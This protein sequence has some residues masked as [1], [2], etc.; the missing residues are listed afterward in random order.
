MLNSIRVRA[1]EAQNANAEQAL[2]NWISK[3]GRSQ[4]RESGFVQEAPVRGAEERDEEQAIIDEFLDMWV[5][6]KAEAIQAINKIETLIESPQKER[7]APVADNFGLEMTSSQRFGQRN[8]LEL[9]QLQH[10]EGPDE[11][12]EP[13]DLSY[14]NALGREERK[15]EVLQQLD[16]HLMRQS[17]L[18]RSKAKALD[19]FAD[20]RGIDL[21]NAEKNDILKTMDLNYDEAAAATNVKRLIDA[22]VQQQIEQNLLRRD[23]W[24]LKD[25]ELR[26]HIEEWLRTYRSLCRQKDMP[27][28]EPHLRDIIDD[29]LR[30]V[31]DKLSPTKVSEKLARERSDNPEKIRRLGDSEILER[32]FIEKEVHRERRVIGK[33]VHRE[34]EKGGLE[35]RRVIEKGGL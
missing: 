6:R 17:F 13:L 31:Q 18:V 11:D 27:F 29:W 28:D 33:E 16:A 23:F 26:E 20:A 25:F 32:R 21:T 4:R 24:R 8:A 5:S 22:F 12:E 15:Q 7:H 1:G 10:P 9:Q 35:G 30:E 34:I 19:D 14:V 2:Q 3:P